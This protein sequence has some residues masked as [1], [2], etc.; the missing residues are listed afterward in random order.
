MSAM[1]EDDSVKNKHF[2]RAE[3]KDVPAFLFGFVVFT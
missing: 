2:L 1:K 3:M